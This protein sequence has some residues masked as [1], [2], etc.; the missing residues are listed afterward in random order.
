MP[1]ES[2]LSPIIMLLE[3]LHGV[4]LGSGNLVDSELVA[5]EI[6]WLQSNDSGRLDLTAA[7]DLVTPAAALLAIGGG[8]EIVGVGHTERKESNRMVTTEGLLFDFGLQAHVRPE[9]V[10]EV[11]GGQTPRAQGDP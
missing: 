7:S 5:P 9:G 2:S 1:S 6:S 4:D 8:G 3:R 10:I 11:P